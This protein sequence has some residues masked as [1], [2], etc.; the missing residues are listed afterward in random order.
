MF[1]NW[2]GILVVV[3]AAILSNYLLNCKAT[4]TF[5]IAVLNFT[6]L[7]LEEVLQRDVLSDTETPLFHMACTQSTSTGEAFTFPIAIWHSMVMSITVISNP[8]HRDSALQS[9]AHC[10]R[11]WTAT[12]FRSSTSREGMVQ[13]FLYEVNPWLE[14]PFQYSLLKR[15]TWLES[16]MDIKNCVTFAWWYEF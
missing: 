12:V 7:G 15:W 9:S 5:D 10:P 8:S 13:L 3:S 2:S 1:S 11:V 4:W 16:T 14:T 6:N